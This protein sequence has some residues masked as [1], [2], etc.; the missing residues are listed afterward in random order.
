MGVEV[1]F[2]D[3]CEPKINHCMYLR[4]FNIPKKKHD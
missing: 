4:K 2:E 3:A 1:T